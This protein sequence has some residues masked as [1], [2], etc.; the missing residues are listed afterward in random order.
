MITVFE[1]KHAVEVNVATKCGCS[2]VIDILGY[3]HFNEFRARKGRSKLIREKKFSRANKL[4]TTDIISISRIAVVRDP[5]ERLIS[6]YT[7]RILKKNRNGMRNYIPSFDY[8]VENLEALQKEFVDLRHHSIPQ[9]TWLGTAPAYY[10][11]ILS[12]KKLQSEFTPLISKISNIS[13][14]QTSHRKQSGRLRRT[15]E[16]TTENKKIIRE[17]YADDYNIYGDYFQ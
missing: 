13:I 3:P 16:V 2:T 12:T 10:N 6:C 1:N 7:D 8:L 14:P 5:V 4:Y 9:I 15:F 17:K 11:Y